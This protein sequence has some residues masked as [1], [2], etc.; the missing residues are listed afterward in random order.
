MYRFSMRNYYCK[1]C[2][3]TNVDNFYPYRTTRCKKCQIKKSEEW[4]NKNFIKSQLLQ[5][6]H[7][8]KR[9]NRIFDLNEDMIQKKLIEQNFK[10]KISNVPLVFN[11][12]S[13]NSMSFDRL[14]ND[15]GYTE[16]NTIVV[17]KFLNN[18]K[19]IYSIDEYCEILEKTYL[20]I[21]NKS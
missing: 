12:N 15:E 3:E 17:T 21:T 1:I 10:C 6:K 16:N 5:T 8:A 11:N 9:D 2:G 13:W 18:S 14:N 4:I 20:G 7:R 19:N